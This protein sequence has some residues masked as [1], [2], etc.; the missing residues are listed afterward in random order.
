MIVLHLKMHSGPGL[1]NDVRKEDHTITTY[2]MAPHE[3]IKAVALSHSLS[4]FLSNK[5]KRTDNL[6]ICFPECQSR[7]FA[8]TVNLPDVRVPGPVFVFG[9]CRNNRSFCCFVGDQLGSHQDPECLSAAGQ[10]LI[11]FTKNTRHLIF[12]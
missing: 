11:R 1:C 6:L 10:L 4:F 2:G 7:N 8:R 5:E 3:L 9:S 12:A